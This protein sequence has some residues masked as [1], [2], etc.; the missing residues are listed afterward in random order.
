MS[1]KAWAEW[2]IA[3]LADRDRA[4]S[5]IGDLLESGGEQN[6]VWF[7]WSV[8][9]VVLSLVSR[10]LVGFAA[11]FL[12][13][14]LSSVWLRTDYPAHLPPWSWTPVFS[15]LSVLCLAAP[16]VLVRYGLRDKFTQLALALCVP[17]A[18]G[19]FY[20]WVPLV[21]L[22]CVLLVLSV[23]VFSSVFI[24]GRKVLLALVGA[25]AFGYAGIRCAFYLAERYLELA[26]PSVTRTVVVQRSLPF[27]CVAMAAAACELMHHFLLQPNRHLNEPRGDSGTAVG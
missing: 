18:V 23:V 2:F 15:V 10:N 12:C 24:A 19:V 6:L 16:Y 3:R 9:G 1:N 4:A 14:W 7:W 8:L 5:I 20:W 26:S 11:A 13:A 21:V 27:L 17:A 25:L 22:P